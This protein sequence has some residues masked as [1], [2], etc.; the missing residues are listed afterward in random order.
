MS[1]QAK[2]WLDQTWQF[3][4]QA[5]GGVWVYSEFGDCAFLTLDELP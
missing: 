5:E 2:A 1:E 4:E 3:W